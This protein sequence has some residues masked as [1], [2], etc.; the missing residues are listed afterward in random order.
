MANLVF[1]HIYG[2][3]DWRVGWN[4]LN[5]SHGRGSIPRMP[6]AIRITSIV[7]TKYTL[8]ICRQFELYFRFVIDIECSR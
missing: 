8:Q 6:N 1:A 2:L 7:W 4:V 5:L 3:F